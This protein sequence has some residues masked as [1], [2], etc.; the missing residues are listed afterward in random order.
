MTLPSKLRSTGQLRDRMNWRLF[1]W[2]RPLLRA[3]EVFHF[4]E[5]PVY[6][7][8]FHGYTL[9][10]HGQHFLKPASQYSCQQVT[11]AVKDCCIN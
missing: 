11:I 4:P 2:R 3:S 9:T 1:I 7:I 8:N 5:S 6:Y 10:F